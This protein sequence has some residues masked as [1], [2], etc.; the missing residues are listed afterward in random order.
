MK[1]AFGQITQDVGLH[2]CSSFFDY[3]MSLIKRMGSLL[4]KAEIALVKP[5]MSYFD[6]VVIS[7]QLVH[8][9]YLLISMLLLH[10]AQTE[11]M[12]VSGSNCTNTVSKNASCYK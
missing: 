3:H 10:S 11:V 8:L 4:N 7:Q 9:L 6:F 1:D 5:L 12:V 2:F